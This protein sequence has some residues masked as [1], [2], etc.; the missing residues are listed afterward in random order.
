M[1][2]ISSWIDKSL[3]AVERAAANA[4]AALRKQEVTERQLAIAR[5][6]LLRIQENTADFPSNKDIATE[7]LQNMGE[8]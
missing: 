3:D 4:R 8:I 5:S 1:A 6:A 2:K 7:A